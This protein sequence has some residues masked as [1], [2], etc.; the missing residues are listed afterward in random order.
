MGDTTAKTAL[1][2]ID[3]GGT[4]V[5]FGAISEAGEVLFSGAK[6]VD[7]AGAPERLIAQLVSIGNELRAG[8]ADRG[9]TATSIGVGTPGVVDVA[10]GEVI[11]GARNI[12]GWAGVK[13]SE[14]LSSALSLSVTVDN[15]AN[16]MALGEL[17]LGAAVG[18]QSALFVTVGTG[19]G[20]ALVLD[21]EVWRGENY[22]GGE[23]CDLLA[24][25][26]NRSS[27]RTR[28]SLEEAASAGALEKRFVELSGRA[29]A[30][31]SEVAEAW[32]A[33]ESAAR[34]AVEEIGE[35]L[36]GTLF[37]L[38][39]ELNLEKVVIGGGVV[40]A[41]PGLVVEVKNSIIRRATA[42]GAPAPEVV[43]AALGNRAGFIGAALL[44]K[45][46]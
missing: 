32:R 37:P 30:R 22:Q 19:I 40:D 39:A 2:G 3:L 21:G 46:L 31:I 24:R 20:G 41:L 36:A 11:S 34:R 6:P 44:P 43:P 35:I 25:E 1:L 33:G 15:D 45:K 18:A 12:P 4:S 38:I 5:K 8:A 26:A 23:I 28:R 27:D 13:L 29:G 17:K 42:A 7:L 10:S 9:Y 16:T 14:A